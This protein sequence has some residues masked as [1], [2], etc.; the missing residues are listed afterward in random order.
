LS[1]LSGTQKIKNFQALLGFP[2][3]S[4][5]A[6]HLPSFSNIASVQTVALQRKFAIFARLF[7]RE[8]DDGFKEKS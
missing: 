7:L 2:S 5:E 8:E 1:T 6:G 4:L 3:A